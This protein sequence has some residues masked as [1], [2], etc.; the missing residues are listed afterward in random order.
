MPRLSQM[1]CRSL[2]RHSL[3]L[4]NPNRLDGSLLLP[5]CK[6]LLR[7]DNKSTHSGVTTEQETAKRKKT[8][9]NW[10]E[11]Q[12]TKPLQMTFMLV[13]LTRDVGSRSGDS[14]TRGDSETRATFTSHLNTVGSR[15]ADARS[16]SS[17]NF[18]TAFTQK[19]R[20]FTQATV[21]CHVSDFNGD[22]TF[23]AAQ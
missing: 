16:I 8:T 22:V 6:A 1:T 7:H 5:R 9:L 17:C 13:K 10:F 20:T 11:F 21:G 2:P 18:R 14:S 4:T 23:D 3:E 19:H 12:P 15:T